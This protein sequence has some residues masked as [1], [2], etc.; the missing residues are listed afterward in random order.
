VV[1]E[2]RG[3]LLVS[4]ARETA[5]LHAGWLTLVVLKRLLALVVVG[6]GAVTAATALTVSSALSLV[7]RGVVLLVVAL[8]VLASLVAGVLLGRAVRHSL[9]VAVLVVVTAVTALHV[10]VGGAVDSFGQGVQIRILLIPSRLQSERARVNSETYKFE[11]ELAPV[12]FHF[13]EVLERSLAALLGLEFD[14]AAALGA[15]RIIVENIDPNNV[16][17]LAHMVLEL[18]P[19]GI[20]VEIGKKNT[21]S[22]HR[23]LIFL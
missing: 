23:I 6:R 19:I 13:V 2:L 20:P 9:G 16:S 3:P 10:L 14:D 7:L 17:R 8:V 15:A 21:S 12:K 11:E 5:A 22:P 4:R 1:V 18:L